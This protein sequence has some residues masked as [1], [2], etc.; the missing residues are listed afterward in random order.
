MAVFSLLYASVSTFTGHEPEAAIEELVAGA[1]KRN[2]AL[3]ITGCL[4]FAGGRF[5]QVLEGEFAAVTALMDR[6]ARDPRHTD[7]TILEQGELPE[8]RFAH[9]ELDYAG[10]SFF[11]QRTISRPVAEATRGS[12]RGID[13]LLKIMTTFRAEQIASPQLPAR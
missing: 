5:A 11:V 2:R 4:I 13:E 10:P 8:R 12:R 9:W 7:V 6:I 1:R 3:D